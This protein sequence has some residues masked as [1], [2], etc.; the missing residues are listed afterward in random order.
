[1]TFPGRL[2]VQFYHE[3]KLSAV[4]LMGTENFMPTEGPQLDCSEDALKSAQEPN[5]NQI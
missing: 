3:M 1:M 5:L 4:R 2:P